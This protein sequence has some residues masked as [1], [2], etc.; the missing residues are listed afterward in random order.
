MKGT[1]LCGT[2]AFEITGTIPHLY[3]CHCSECR[4]ATGGAANAATLVDEADFRWLS[5]E[6]CISS[7]SG[8]SGYR[9][10][11]C[12][13]CGSPVPNR[14]KGGEK[15]WVP[16]GLLEEADD[17]AVAIHLY[18]GSQAAWERSA[19]EAPRCEESPGLDALVKALR[20]TGR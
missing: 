12:S 3:Q 5:G 1:C 7:F 16:A 14:L 17:L 9:S 11:F 8:E 19:Q 18:T 10:D 20:R 4:K 13:V 15:V 2:V 6:Q